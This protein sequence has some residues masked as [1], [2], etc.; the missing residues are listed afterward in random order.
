MRSSICFTFT[1]LLLASCGGTETDNPLA[2]FKRTGCKNHSETALTLAADTASSE[3]LPA[4]TA[5][6]GLYCFEYDYDEGEKLLDVHVYNY[7]SGCGSS[8]TGASATSR[9]GW[10]TLSV[11][12]SSCTVA[13]CGSC[14]FD[15]S[16]QV[17]DFE[18]LGGHMV[19][20]VET[21]CEGTPAEQ[22]PESWILE[23]GAQL[24]SGTRAFCRT[25]GEPAACEADDDCR[26]DLEQCGD[27]GTCEPR[28]PF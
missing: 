12:R 7:P 24:E 1:A 26:A 25:I 20:L 21:G 14:L 28:L 2:D 6:D 17:A 3:P 23:A 15:F 13:R 5:H 16:F 18:L 10:L 19:E 4:D 8:F 22:E 9:E 11:Q 27:S